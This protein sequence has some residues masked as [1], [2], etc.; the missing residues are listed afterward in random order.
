[1]SVAPALFIL[2]S[3]IQ[4]SDLIS[5]QVLDLLQQKQHQFWTPVGLKSVPVQCEHLA[6]FV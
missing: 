5:L 4:Y 2:Y 1:M 6:G 3:Y